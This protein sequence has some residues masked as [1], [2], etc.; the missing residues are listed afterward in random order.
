MMD[1]IQAVY[2]TA[3]RPALALL[4]TAMTSDRAL[5]PMIAIGLQESRLEHRYQIVQGKPGAKGPA[6]GLWQFER[7]S[8]W[9]GGGV[10]GVFKHK[11]SRFWLSELCKARGVAFDPQDIWQRLEHDD[12]LA[13]G[14]ARLLLFTDAQPLP[15]VH[16][17][18]GCWVLYA[19]RTW[20]PGK[21]HPETWPRFHSAA[22]EFVTEVLEA[23]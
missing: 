8:Q 1:R 2:D 3:I 10:W 23:A 6:R 7:G 11:A 9:L 20:R 17:V 18:E 12:V 14:V 21:P 19:K 16:D 22:C 4:P 13:G 15:S 5:V